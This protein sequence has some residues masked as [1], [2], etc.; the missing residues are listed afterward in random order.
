MEWE[1]EER[2]TTKR[3][4]ISDLIELARFWEGSV[5]IRKGE[6]EIKIH[7]VKAMIDHNNTYT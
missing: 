5:Q 7:G 2:H 1:R 6:R 3:W 4:W